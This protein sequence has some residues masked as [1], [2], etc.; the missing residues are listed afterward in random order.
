[1]ELKEFLKQLLETPN[2]TL[3]E[4]SVLLEL[5]YADFSRNDILKNEDRVQI[6]TY[7]PAALTRT[8]Q[9]LINK[10]LVSIREDSIEK[11]YTLIN[12]CNCYGTYKTLL[13]AIARS[14]FMTLNIIRTALYLIV[15]DN[16]YCTTRF[17]AKGINLD[18]DYIANTILPRM[19]V[20]KIIKFVKI[21]Q[22]EEKNYRYE[23]L[24]AGPSLVVFSLDDSWNGYVPERWL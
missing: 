19:H 12:R 7:S 6:G 24:K 17:I 18:P 22:A 2:L 8:L 9:K 4:L 13:L 5:G 16:M 3:N 21:N 15:N 20:I 14:K 23:D 11:K 10:G 1:M